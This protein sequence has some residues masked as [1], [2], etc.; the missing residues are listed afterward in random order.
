MIAF[1]ILH[2]VTSQEVNKGKIAFLADI[3]FQDLYGNLEDS[4]YKGV[5]NST[6]NRTTL[7]RTMASQLQS[8]RIFNENYFA[9]LATLNDIVERNIKVVAL[10]GDYS[11]D[12]QPLHVRGL[13]KILE[14]Y[15]KEHDIQFFITTGN[16]DPA[17][18]FLKDSGKKDFLGEQGKKQ[19]LYSEESMYV[20]KPAI[21]H[22]VVVTKDI[23]KMGYVEIMETLKDFGFYPQKSFL[24]WETPFSNYTPQT[25]Q[26]KKA[27]KASNIENRTYPLKNNLKIPDASYLVEP[28]DGL[29]L[30]AID[31][32]S[33][34]PESNGNFSG[35]GLG[36]NNSIKYK[37]H[38]FSWFSKV[39]KMA[40]KLNK[41]LIAFS[42]Y[43]AIDFNEDASPRIEEFFGGKKWQLKRV[44]EEKIA[45]KIAEAGIKIHVAG[46][47]HINDTGKRDYGN[48][49]FLVNIQTPSLA[50]YIPGY[51]TLSITDNE[52]EVETIV[53]DEV[54][55]FKELF[56]LYEMEYNYLKKTNQPLW[57]STILQSKSYHEFTEFHLEN[58]VK[59]RFYSDWNPDFFEFLSNLTGKELLMLS[60][61]QQEEDIINFFATK[62]G[63]AESDLKNLN[64]YENWTG[65]D[66][67]LDFYKIRNADQL[68]FRDIPQQRLEEYKAILNAFQKNTF[69]KNTKHAY[70]HQLQLFMNIFKSFIHGVPANHFQINLKSGE[71]TNLEK[72]SSPEGF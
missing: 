39:A 11:D 29:W 17:G 7:L 62:E 45:E 35:A 18:P 14:Y 64:Q 23:A 40:K 71:V 13:R 12:G 34:I 9:F 57:D 33:Y 50:A 38:L 36:Y 19:P 46:H 70:A 43:P 5:L 28:V 53:I 22:P 21:E 60:E 10:P 61:N 56:S 72:A 41:T 63:L 20:S 59:N 27:L 58:L 67:I 47:M 68:A 30:L 55:R 24:Y 32:N 42:H 26:Y 25:Y 1:F 37:Q 52:V 4:E 69:F 54:P 49:N 44:P 48:G 3:H 2:Q 31:G 8:T 51:K 6:N 15:A 65:I 66:M 16:H